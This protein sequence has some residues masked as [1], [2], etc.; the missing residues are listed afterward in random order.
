MFEKYPKTFGQV[1][2]TRSIKE[3]VWLFDTSR[4]TTGVPKLSFGIRR[5]VQRAGSL[6]WLWFGSLDASPTTACQS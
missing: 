3:P 4:D 1:L 5:R 6:R 2:I